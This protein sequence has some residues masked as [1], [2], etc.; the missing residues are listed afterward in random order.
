MSASNAGHW[1]GV[2]L[3]KRDDETSWFQSFP[4]VSLQLL[5]HARLQP[6]ARIID[7]GA[8]RS[9]LVEG[10]LDRGHAH[11]TLLELSGEALARTRERLGERAESVQFVTGDV[12]AFHPPRL[13]DAWHDRAVFHFLVSPEDRARYV[14]VLERAVKPGGQ[15]VMG[16][17]A[18]DGPAKCSG[19]PVARYDGRGLSEVLGP[20]FALEESVR[21]LHVTPSG[22]LQAF[23]FAR[24]VRV[25]R[26]A[27]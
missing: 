2:Y 16:T 14:A 12:T 9:R 10:L 5:A 21:D 11:V 19:L 17:F 1:D 8:G 3:R 18:L 6:E 4:E 22:K 24:F 25:P 15:V 13:Y 27:A 20:A 26:A 23:T 7:V